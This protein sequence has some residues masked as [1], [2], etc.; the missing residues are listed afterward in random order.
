MRHTLI[1][2]ITAMAMTLGTAAHA[3][4]QSSAITDRVFI[5]V[6]F[7]SQPKVRDDA[8]H[9]AVNLFLEEGSV[10]VA[11][12]TP[13]GTFLDVTGGLQLKGPFGVA[14]NVMQRKADK[15][16]T[17]SASLP[18]P[19]FYDEPQVL[20]D[21]IS[22]LK[23]RETWIAV[24]A[25]YELAALPKGIAVTL[26]AG[27]AVATVEHEVVTDI[28]VDATTQQVQA[29]LALMKRDLLGFQVGADVRWMLLRHLGVGG[30]IRYNA[31]NGHLSATKI[32]LG[33]MQFGGGVRVR[34]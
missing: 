22:G 7:G 8:S 17:L 24:L 33:G 32:E 4:A 25:S 3:A 23:H 19:F 10:D 29:N 18:S 1:I 12:K 2:G 15:D 21:G 30:Y 11:R 6:N 9:F 5:N 34:F 20:S 27:P 26:L 13:G 28:T 14:V 31:A 16:G